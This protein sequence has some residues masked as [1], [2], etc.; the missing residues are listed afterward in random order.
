[1]K[2]EY[3]NTYN[4]LIKLSRNKNLYSEFT[5]KDTFSHRLTILL[6]HFAF[7]IKNYKNK[8]TKKKIQTIYDCFF[9]NLEIN[10]RE[11][12]FGDTKIN[13]NMK[14]YNNIFYYV[15]DK[16]SLWDERSIYEKES[17]ISNLLEIKKKPLK[18]TKYFERFDTYLKKN[19]LNCF[20]KGVINHKF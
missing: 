6:I 10:L 19:P 8:S 3:L 4:N 17:I 13:K 12:G 11:I 20:L 9:K 2:I 1:M 15:L 18:L 5:D 16:I 14:N 7:F